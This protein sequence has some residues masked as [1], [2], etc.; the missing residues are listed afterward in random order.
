MT[1]E[2]H[3]ALGDQSI[4][5]I[6]VYSAEPLTDAALVAALGLTATRYRTLAELPATPLELPHPQ[7]LLIIEGKVVP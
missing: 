3:V 1:L 5:V 7:K 6:V 4:G 2:G